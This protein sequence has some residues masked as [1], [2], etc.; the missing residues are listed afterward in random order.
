MNLAAIQPYDLATFPLAEGDRGTAETMKLAAKLVD[1]GLKDPRIRRAATEMLR[2]VAAYDE[3][4]EVAKIFHD[5]LTPGSP[6]YVRYTKHMIGKQTFQAAADVL[7]TGA[8]DCLAVNAILFPALLGSV[9]YATRA[10]T[11]KADPLEPDEFSHVYLEVEVPAQSG[12]WI[13]LDAA[14]PD[15][16]F[17]L[18]PDPETVWAEE[19][20]PLTGSAPLLGRAAAR[21]SVVV[22]RGFMP[23]FGGRR[24]TIV[25]RLRGVG[26]TAADIS[27][28]LAQ[29]PS[30]LGGTAQIVQAANAPG[31]APYY[32]PGAVSPYGTPYPSSGAVTL[33][34]G[35]SSTLLLFGLG[36]VLAIALLGGRH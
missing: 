32:L 23:S 15:A 8:G 10:V 6:W 34:G 19:R 5:V 2:P 26:Q 30:I 28:V 22:R 12:N 14:R 13:A 29:V 11:I 20:W 33:S 31:I 3:T 4:A 16:A 25:R 1:A 24:T 18:A 36:V 21:P 35:G 9:G 7:T 17:G 27:T